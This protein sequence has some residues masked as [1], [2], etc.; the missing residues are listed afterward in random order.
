MIHLP[1]PIT[2][3]GQRRRIWAEDEPDGL[4]VLFMRSMVK[5]AHWNTTRVGFM[6]FIA[7]DTCNFAQVYVRW[8][9]N[10]IVGPV[11]I[12]SNLARSFEAQK[13]SS[14]CILECRTLNAR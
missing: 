3:R 12:Y 8:K 7:E 4:T 1:M 6:K 9:S 13:Q 11:H 10:L 5:E 14:I 2:P